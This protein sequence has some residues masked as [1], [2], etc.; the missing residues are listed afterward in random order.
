VWLYFRARGGYRVVQ[1]HEV[2]AAS[3]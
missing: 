3:K 2:A 1:I